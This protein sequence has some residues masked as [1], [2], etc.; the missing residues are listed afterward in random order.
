MVAVRTAAVSGQDTPDSR[1]EER[2]R[3]HIRDRVIVRAAEHAATEVSG[4]RGLSR[5]TGGRGPVRVRVHTSGDIITLRL[6]AGIDYPHPVR[7]VAARAREHIRQRVEVLT[8]KNV[9]H[10]D[11]EIAELVR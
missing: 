5:P 1:P 9:R 6:R 7:E 3:V 8:G 10:V 2:G 4:V 11:V